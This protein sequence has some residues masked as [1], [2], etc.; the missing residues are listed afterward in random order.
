MGHGRAAR[1]AARADSFLPTWRRPRAF[2]HGCVSP[3]TSISC[4]SSCWSVAACKSSWTIPGCTGTSTAP[5]GRNG[6]DSRPIEV[7]T[8]RVWTAKE[9]SR[10]LSP[11]IGLPG[12][13]HTIG[14]AR[15]W[16]FLSVL[17]WVVERCCLCR[18]AVRHGPV[19]ATRA[20]FLAGRTRRL[21]VLRPL[22]HLPPSPG[23]GHVLSATTRSSNLT[24]FAVVFVLAPL[25]ILTG[26][27]MSPAFTNRFKWYPKLPGNRQIGRSLHFLI[28]CAFVIFLVGHVAMVVL[29][30][31]RPEHEPHRR[32]H[33]RH[34]D[35]GP[36]PRRRG[37][38]GRGGGERPGELAGV[39][40]S[41]GPSSTL[42]RP[43]SRRSCG[44]SS[45]ALSRKPSF[46]ERTSRRS[47]GPTASC[48][49][50]RSGRRWPKTI[51]GTT[52]S[53]CTAWWRTRS[54][55]RWMTSGRWA[56]R[57]RSRCTTASRGGRASPPGAD[58]RW[59]NWSNWSDPSRA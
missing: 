26:P 24:Y 55:C 56:R 46:A 51:S 48:P 47:F 36:L 5:Q 31:L 22:R 57:R 33:Q 38:R 25:A 12:Y 54:S 58:C 42:R 6:F 8:D 34:D 2:R 13:R 16:H 17:F 40:A 35:A 29:T 23:A 10:Y 59:P 30:G 7:P 3:T 53:K 32:G 11:W 49:P 41:H 4:S 50:A 14:M 44:T 1:R 45:T 39:E 18:P 28:M 37:D 43:S 27:S 52:G 19:E 21:G 20:D 15:H 9:D